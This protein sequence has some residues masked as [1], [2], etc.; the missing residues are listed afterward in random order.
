MNRIIK[1][2]AIV[3]TISYFLVIYIIYQLVDIH[4]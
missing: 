2:G 1:K 4:W 3:T